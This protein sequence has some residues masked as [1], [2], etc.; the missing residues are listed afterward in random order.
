L[1]KLWSKAVARIDAA[2]LRERA[3][4]FFAAALLVV[5]FAETAVLQP[6]FTSQRRLASDLVQRQEELKGLQQQIAKLVQDQDADP[7]KALRARVAQL[8]TGIEQAERRVAAEQARF[9]EPGQMKRVVEELLAKNRRIRLVDLKT[10]QVQSIADL[11]EQ[12][13]KPAATAKPGP[14][15][16][17]ERQIFRHGIEITVTGSYLDLLAYISELERLPTQLYWSSIEMAVSQYPVV[18]AKLKIYTLSLDKAWM[19]V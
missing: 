13:A 7:D 6:E 8:H 11:R 10:L 12:D 15:A 16:A 14:A 18:T 19:N 1:K 5:A 4:I 17:A 2:S 3:I 9:T